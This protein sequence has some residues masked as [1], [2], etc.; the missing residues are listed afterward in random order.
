MLLR[1]RLTA[2]ERWLEHELRDVRPDH[3]AVARHELS[4]K[5]ILARD[6]IRKLSVR[7]A[8]EK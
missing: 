8:A 5:E 7:S 2:E 1:N 4:A 6:R 3:I